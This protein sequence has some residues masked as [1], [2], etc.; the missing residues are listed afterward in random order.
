MKRIFEYQSKMPRSSGRG[1]KNDFV[2][3]KWRAR[4]SAC[5]LRRWPLLRLCRLSLRGS[6]LGLNLIHG[7]NATKHIHRCR[8]DAQNEAGIHEPN[9]PRARLGVKARKPCEVAYGK[10]R[11]ERPIQKQA[12][13]PTNN[14]VVATFTREMNRNA[15]LVAST[16]VCSRQQSAAGRE[17]SRAPRSIP[18]G[19]P[20]ATGQLRQT[21]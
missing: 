18:A 10:A 7:G 8:V 21:P 17:R 6:A 4:Q 3:R 19:A 9:A 2:L 16:Q 1:I 11:N 13:K 15:R 14:S 12:A 20:R 5:A